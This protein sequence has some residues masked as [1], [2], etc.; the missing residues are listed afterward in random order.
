[1]DVGN[2]GNFARMLWLYGGNAGAMRQDLEG[3]AFTD[4]QTRAAI[5]R[6]FDERRY[7]VDPHSAVAWLGLERARSARKRVTGV[8]LATAHPAKFADV[9]EPAIGRKVEIPARLAEC[10][11]RQPRT[12]RV[13]NTLASVKASLRA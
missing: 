12:T 7:V 1:M 8:F 2:P 6:T 5:A 10:L 9:V 13:D 11:A 4:D 3:H